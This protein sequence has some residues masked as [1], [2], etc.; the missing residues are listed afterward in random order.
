MYLFIKRIDKM[1]KN[2]DNNIKIIVK[3]NIFE[4][5]RYVRKVICSDIIKWWCCFLKIVGSLLKISILNIWFVF[6][7][8]F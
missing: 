4:V 1:G 3:S 5:I 7:D 6:K 8:L 2:K